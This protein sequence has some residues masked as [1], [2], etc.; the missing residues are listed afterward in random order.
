MLFYIWHSHDINNLDH[1]KFQGISGG[2]SVLNENDKGVRI[3]RKLNDLSYI[4]NTVR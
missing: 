3:I 2:V 4:S 1:T